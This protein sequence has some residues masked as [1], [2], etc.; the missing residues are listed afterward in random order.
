MAQITV[1]EFRN[2]FK[3]YVGEEHQQ[4]GIDELFRNLDLNSKE[5]DAKWMHLYRTAPA[6]SPPKLRP[7]LEALA[8]I[9]GDAIPDPEAEQETKAEVTDGSVLLKV[10]YQ[11]QLDNVSGTG[12][13]E[14][15]SSSCAMVAMYYGKIENDDAYNVVRQKYGDSTDAAAQ[16]QTLRELGLEAKFIT[17]GATE[18]VRRL[19]EKGQPVPVGWLHKGSV[20]APTGGGHWS[21]IVGYKPGNWIVN[22][23]NGEASLANGGYTNNTY[24]HNLDYSYKNFNPRWIVSGE[25]DGWYLDVSDPVKQSAS[26][27]KKALSTSQIGVDL[28]KLFEGCQTKAY[29]CP[30]GVLTIGY[31][32]T[33]PDVRSGMK[34]TESEAERLLKEDL[35]RFENAVNRLIKVPLTQHEFDA[36]VSFAFNVGSSALEH[37]TFCRRM[38]AGQD[39]AT[40]LKEEFPKCVN[41]SNGPL[42]GLVRRRE[43]EVGLAVA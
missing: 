12:Y 14:C 15:F 23:P 39:K 31:G 7:T 42:P 38:N 20:S 41:G 17:N 11:S 10:P 18:D 2:F 4:R 32:H 30:S 25:G 5:D 19:L 16:V 13:R 28:I 8:Q 24:G 26:P 22:D 9:I 35:K 3:Y 6:K 27:N 33:G 29:V 34:I 21:V 43:A 37:S 40:C 36:I 1:E